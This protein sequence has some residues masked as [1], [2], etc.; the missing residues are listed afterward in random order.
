[1]LTKEKP[2]VVFVH[3]ECENLGVEALSSFLKS[4]GYNCDLVF[5]PRALDSVSFHLKPLKDFFNEDKDTVRQVISKR[6]DLVAFSV[7]TGSYQWAL[8]IANMIKQE[9]DVP[10]IFGGIHPTSVPERVLNN[11]CVDFVCMGEGELPLLNIMDRIKE[12][13]EISGIE[14]IWHRKDGAVIKNPI[15]PLISDLDSLGFPDKDLFYK[16]FPRFFQRESYMTMS[17]RGCPFKCTYCCNDVYI[18]LFKD[19]GR[20]VRRRSVG[21][22]IEELDRGLGKY[23]FKR[24][25]FQDDVFATDPNWL[26]DFA[27]SYTRHIKRPYTCFLHPQLVTYEILKYLKKSGCFWLKMGLQSASE[28]TRREVLQRFESNEKIKEVGKW[29]HELRLDFTIDH[30]FNLPREGKDE[31]IEAIKLY[32]ELRP[33]SINTFSLLYFPNTKIVDIARR[34]GILNENDIERI[35]EGKWQLSN[36]SG[37]AGRDPLSKGTRNDAAIFWFSLIALLPWKLIDYF[38]RRRFIEKK[39]RAPLFVQ[40]FLKVLSKIK[41]RQVYIYVYVVSSSIYFT[42]KLL[43]G[44]LL[45]KVS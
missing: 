30:I 45:K 20:F 13:R 5:S 12:G 8:N 14:N 41:A 39:F 33:S 32:N 9:L 17:G 2:S 28:K 7:F 1:M 4:N 35:N 27:D 23:N 15:R 10:V 44:R 34:E 24:V 38:I 3:S 11:S 16:N 26:S 31:Q 19:K 22:V 25:D 21:H 37:F 43:K 42:L 29:C 36:I 18:Q 40:V 6:P